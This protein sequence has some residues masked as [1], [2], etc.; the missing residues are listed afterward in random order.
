MKNTVEKLPWVETCD[1]E[2]SFE[3]QWSTD[4]ITEIGKE[5]LKKLGIAPPPEN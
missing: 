3:H 5:Q 2:F 4:L 1:V